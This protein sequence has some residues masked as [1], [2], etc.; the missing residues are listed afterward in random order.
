MK[1][2]LLSEDHIR[3]D[4]GPGALTIEAPSADAVYS[5]FHMLAS[6]LAT[7]VFSV[8]HSWATHA[9]LSADDLAIDVEWEFAEQPHRV[10]AYRL[11]LDWPSLPEGR[12]K[13]AE[14]AAAL[15]PVHKTLE[16]PTEV[17]TEVSIHVAAGVNS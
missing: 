5:P 10:G 13:A 15:C 1:I 2:T 4:P 11:A 9:D 7:C 3:L 12:R 17:A 14:R 16:H 6:G 8:L